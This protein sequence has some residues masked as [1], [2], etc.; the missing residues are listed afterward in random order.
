MQ[1]VGDGV[2]RLVQRQAGHVDAAVDAEADGA[3][4]P[5]QVLPVD[6]QVRQGV[7]PWQR[8]KQNVRRFDDIG[9]QRLLGEL[10]RRGRVTR[11]QRAGHNRLR[12]QAGLFQ[13]GRPGVSLGELPRRR[14]R[15][16]VGMSM[17][18]LTA[19]RRHKAAP[20]SRDI[21]R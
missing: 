6:G 12:L 17:A 1:L 4:G 7:R 15:L 11:A 2:A 20:N 9:R 8:H 10:A 5:D 21:V 18:A 14:S 19:P 13:L 16:W 3:V